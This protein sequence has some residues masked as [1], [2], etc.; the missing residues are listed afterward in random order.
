MRN[1]QDFKCINTTTELDATKINVL[2]ACE[3][4]Q[5]ECAAFRRYG[6]NAYSCDVEPCRGGA[7]Q[8]HIN[9]AVEPFLSGVVKF[10][11]QDGVWHEI[12]KW[13]LII[14]H[15]PCTYLC[16]MSSVH[17]IKGGVVQQDRLKK[18]ELARDFFL[19]CLN[20]QAE[21]VAVENP[22][23]MARA[24]L[25]KRSFE[26]DPFEFGDRWSKRTLYWVRNLPPLMPTKFAINYSS[27]VKSRRGKYRSTA[28]LGIANAMARQWGDYV[29]LHLPPDTL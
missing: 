3:C 21:F 27:F 18:M 20:A 17:M 11:T 13:H 23:P 29:L 9:S 24:Q 25:P 10:M 16:K 26:V 7:P 8:Y 22:R 15:P 6:F 2:V 4:S 14:A 28:F 19:K 5:I 12:S 1:Y